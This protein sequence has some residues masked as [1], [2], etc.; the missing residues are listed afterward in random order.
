MVVGMK[1]QETE[2]V[3]DA[4]AKSLGRWIRNKRE[5]KSS[6]IFA[7]IVSELRKKNRDAAFMYETH[8]D[9]A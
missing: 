1:E 8:K 7:R 5:V 3:C 9:V 2:K 4:V 6:Q